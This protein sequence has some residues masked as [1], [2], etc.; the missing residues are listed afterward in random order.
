M[1]I[2]AAMKL[3]RFRHDEMAWGVWHVAHLTAYA[4]QKP[5]DFVKLEKLK[6]RDPQRHAVQQPDWRSQLAKVTAWVKGK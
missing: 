4:P 6:S 1:V 5:R 3:R 2:A